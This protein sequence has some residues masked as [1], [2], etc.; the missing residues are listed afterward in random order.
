VC[1]LDEPI[2]VSP[3]SLYDHGEFSLRRHFPSVLF[4]NGWFHVVTIA[5]EVAASGRETGERRI[6]DNLELMPG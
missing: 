6:G 1:T 2:H 5:D 3:L 4:T